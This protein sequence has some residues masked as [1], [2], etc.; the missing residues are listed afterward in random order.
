MTI[1]ILE[2]LKKS[3]PGLYPYF[4]KVAVEYL[5]Q[6]ELLNVKAKELFI[7]RGE[8]DS[9]AIFL[10][11]QGICDNCD[12]SFRSFSLRMV[13][14]DVV[15]LIEA[16]EK[17]NIPRKGAARA[18]TDAKLIKI[19]KKLL[20]TVLVTQY[21]EL[22][23]ELVRRAI[24][25]QWGA[26][27]TLKGYYLYTPPVGLCMYLINQ[28]ELFEKGGMLKGDKLT[29]LDTRKWISFEMGRSE[30]S[31]NRDI[32]ALKAE[33]LITIKKGKIIVTRAQYDKMCEIKEK[34]NE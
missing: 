14:G 28:Y 21:T 24:S 33:G 27:S 22:F 25:R 15:G 13:P 34:S 9:N 19:P 2:L 10:L 11:V 18:F 7:T 16:L 6:M 8:C 26:C 29:V 5:E 20:Q 4:G 32:A 12:D 1:E 30:K 3:C 17:E 23:L 31:T